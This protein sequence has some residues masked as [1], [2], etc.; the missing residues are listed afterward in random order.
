[1]TKYIIPLFLISFCIFVLILWA[2]VYSIVKSKG[3][4]TRRKKW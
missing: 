3:K 4:K 2:A 1:M